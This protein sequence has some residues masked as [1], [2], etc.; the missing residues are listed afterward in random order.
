MIHFLEKFWIHFYFD[1]CV[2]G[3]AELDV[4]LICVNRIYVNTKI[5]PL[6]KI[7]KRL[8]RAF[9]NIRFRTLL[10]NTH[11]MSVVQYQGCYE[12]LWRWGQ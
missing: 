10:F 5:V 7:F 2:I 6:S 3:I 11:Q 8:P 1:I 4:R 12:G 9:S